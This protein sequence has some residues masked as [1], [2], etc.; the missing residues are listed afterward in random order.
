MPDAVIT[1]SGT[2]YLLGRLV[3]GGF[4][5]YAD[6]RFGL[7]TSDTTPLPTSILADFNR[8]G[9]APSDVVMFPALWQ[10]PPEP[11]L[12]QRSYWGTEATEFTAI[13]ATVT[14]YGYCVWVSNDPGLIWAQRFDAPVV[15]V[16]G[17]VVRV[18]P[19]FEYGQCP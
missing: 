11:E 1:T 7:F 8:S 5:D 18:W 9:I 14:V 10:E 15:L 3:N 4:T 16:A 12:R 6:F 13:P 2:K 17:Q 19:F